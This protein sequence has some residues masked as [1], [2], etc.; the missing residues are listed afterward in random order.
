MPYVPISVKH[1]VHNGSS[2]QYICLIDHFHQGPCRTPD[3]ELWWPSSQ[4][5]GNR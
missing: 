4:P 1:A 2:E 3:G 5:K